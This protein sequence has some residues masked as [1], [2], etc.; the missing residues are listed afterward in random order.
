MSR[1]R[2]ERGVDL[3]VWISIHGFDACMQLRD[4]LQ[5][6]SSQSDTPSATLPRLVTWHMHALNQAFLPPSGPAKAGHGSCV[7]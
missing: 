1:V 4:T 5:P 6:K 2:K 7:L 3:E